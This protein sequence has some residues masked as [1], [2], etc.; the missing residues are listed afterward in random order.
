MSPIVGLITADCSELKLK[1]ETNPAAFGKWI[2]FQFWQKAKNENT[3]HL[4]P[5]KIEISQS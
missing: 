3:T 5:S 2:T 1:E 4:H